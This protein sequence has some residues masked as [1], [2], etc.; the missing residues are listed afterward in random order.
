MGKAPRKSSDSLS[1][2]NRRL[3]KALAKIE[4]LESREPQTLPHPPARKWMTLRYRG[5]HQ[6]QA[7]LHPGVYNPQSKLLGQVMATCTAVANVLMQMLENYT[8]WGQKARVGARVLWRRKGKFWQGRGNATI[9]EGSFLHRI[10]QELAVARDNIFNYNHSLSDHFGKLPDEDIVMHLHSELERVVNDLELNL[11]RR[12]RDEGGYV[13][14]STAL[15]K[16]RNTV[17]LAQ[18]VLMAPDAPGLDKLIEHGLE[19]Y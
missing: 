1:A 3:D 16:L 12:H 19:R 10:Y 14:S 2:V 4:Q 13:G 9:N 7:R 18:E 8:G 17:A 11:K 6:K 5:H 15:R